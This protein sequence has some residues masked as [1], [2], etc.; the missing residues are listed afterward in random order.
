MTRA[1][2]QPSEATSAASMIRARDQ[3]AA[4]SASQAAR[5][6]PGPARNRSMRKPKRSK[7]EESS[8]V[9]ITGV[10]PRSSAAAASRRAARAGSASGASTR[11]PIH[12]AP[13][14]PRSHRQGEG[15]GV[16]AIRPAS[17]PPVRAGPGAPAS[18]STGSPGAI[19]DRTASQCRSEEHTS[20]LQSR[21]NLVCRLLLEKKKKL[22]YQNQ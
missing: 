11:M 9:R 8:D 4:I 20:E 15:G 6:T 1:P 16:A 14:S 21:E 7:P 17:P 2:P 10:T 22:N 13:V 18:R 5:S 3:K 12:E 19:R